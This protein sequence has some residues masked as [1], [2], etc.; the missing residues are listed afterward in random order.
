VPAVEFH[1]CPPDRSARRE[2]WDPEVT[3]GLSNGLHHH[4]CLAKPRVINFQHLPENGVGHLVPLRFPAGSAASGSAPP[5]PARQSDAASRGPSGLN[6][7]VKIG[8]NWCSTKLCIAPSHGQK[9]YIGQ[10]HHPSTDR[11]TKK[12]FPRYKTETGGHRSRC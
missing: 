4:R 10:H 1:R 2:Q 11:P 12:H 8:D 6:Q 7:G 5:A 3:S 9:I